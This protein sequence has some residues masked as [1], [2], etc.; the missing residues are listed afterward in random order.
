MFH[1]AI[2]LM[3]LRGT[4]LQVSFDDGVVKQYDMASL[5]VKYPQLKQLENRPLF[6]SGKLISPYGIIWN[7]DLDIETETIYVEGRTV[8][9]KAEISGIKVG[10][11]LCEARARAELSQKKLSEISGIDQSDISKIERG[12]ANPSVM[13]LERLAKALDCELEIDFLHK[14]EAKEGKKSIYHYEDN[15]D[16]LK[17]AEPLP[18]YGNWKRCQESNPGNG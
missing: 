14:K 10:K 6:L 15:T 13:T 2:D 4:R 9:K 1:R 17:V 3:F 7:D 12:V 8:D 16:F 18:N 11:A 5:F